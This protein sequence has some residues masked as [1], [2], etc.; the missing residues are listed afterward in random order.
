VSEVGRSVAKT[1]I[2]FVEDLGEM[3][4]PVGRARGLTGKKTAGKTA[5]LR[6]KPPSSRL[7]KS[8]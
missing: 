6:A 2:K 8:K 7:K 4:E 3:L 1:T 5:K